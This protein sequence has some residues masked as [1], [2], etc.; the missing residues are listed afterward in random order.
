M[1]LSCIEN[2]NGKNP[3]DGECL[4]PV[5]KIAGIFPAYKDLTPAVATSLESNYYVHFSSKCLFHNI[6]KTRLLGP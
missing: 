1:G 3:R 5:I 2:I 4:T 6:V